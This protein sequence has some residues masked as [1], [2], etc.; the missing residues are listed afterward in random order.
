MLL[1][2]MLSLEKVS[3]KGW[4]PYLRSV[5]CAV[6]GEPIKL[7]AYLFEE[8][9]KLTGQRALRK[10]LPQVLRPATRVRRQRPPQP[11]VHCFAK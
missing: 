10:A 9:I 7:L 6:I 4:N 11:S 2:P 1:A 3:K 8:P 5:L